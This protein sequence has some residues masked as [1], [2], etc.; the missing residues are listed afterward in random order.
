LRS[1][2]PSDGHLAVMVAADLVLNLAHL[3]HFSLI[4]R[5]TDSGA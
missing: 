1:A 5:C 3:P 2:Q 4:H